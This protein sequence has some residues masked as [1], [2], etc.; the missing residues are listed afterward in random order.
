MGAHS[1][2]LKV[3]LDWENPSVNDLDM[4]VYDIGLT[5]AYEVAESGSRYE[6]DYFNSTNDAG[7]MVNILF[8]KKYTIQMDRI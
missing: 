1:K 2:A 3:L 8:I 4:Y 5:A 6:G 7:L